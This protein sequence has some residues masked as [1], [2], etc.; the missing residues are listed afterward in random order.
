MCLPCLGSGAGFLRSAAVSEEASP[1][2]A[3]SVDRGASLK[4]WGL[5][6]VAVAVRTEEAVALQPGTPAL[7]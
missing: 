5:G 7:Q 2:R 3:S 1:D 6:A 4:N